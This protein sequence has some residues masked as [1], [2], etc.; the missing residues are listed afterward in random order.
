MYPYALI[1]KENIKSNSIKD[2]LKSKGLFF[3][4]FYFFREH[5]KPRFNLSLDV[6]N[7]IDKSNYLYYQEKEEFYK[8]K[9]L[10]TRSTCF[11]HFFLHKILHNGK[12]INSRLQKEEMNEIVQDYQ[13]MIIF[14]PNIQVQFVNE[15][16]K[17]I[18]SYQDMEKDEIVE[19]LIKYA[20]YW[21]ECRINALYA[22]L[23]LEWMKEDNKWLIKMLK[24]FI[25]GMLPDI[26]KRKKGDEFAQM[27]YSHF[28]DYDL[29]IS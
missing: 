8:N 11:E 29:K 14:P 3:H 6:E 25:L 15:C 23:V 24:I 16:N 22:S 4:Y 9:H 5:L 10:I 27:V 20:F 17:V 13:T 26:E 12:P 28:Y 18:G 21:D 7:F 19:K 1:S 2:V